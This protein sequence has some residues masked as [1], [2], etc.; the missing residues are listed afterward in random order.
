MS[1]LYP[2]K[3]DFTPKNRV[4]IFNEIKNNS[5]DAVILTHD[6]F[7]MIPQ[8]P[9]IQ[10]QIFQKEPDSVEENQMVPSFQRIPFFDN[11]CQLLIQLDPQSPEHPQL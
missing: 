10:Q 9:E 4:K 11:K 8:S 5:W 2:G 7:G 1:I 6:Q 3:E